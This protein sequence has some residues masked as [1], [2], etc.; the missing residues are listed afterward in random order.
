MSEQKKALKETCVKYSME[1]GFHKMRTSE[2]N[3]IVKRLNYDGAFPK[4]ARSFRDLTLQQAKESA[5]R[6]GVY[7]P[8]SPVTTGGMASKWAKRKLRSQQTA[9]RIE[10]DQLI[11]RER[12]AVEI[13][14]ERYR[15]EKTPAQRTTKDIHE[16]EALRG[17]TSAGGGACIKAP[18]A[19]QTRVAI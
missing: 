15:E 5:R 17:T 4:N 16:T 14:R 2:F 3:D 8:L 9:D 1:N 18:R 12:R 10:C 13:E 19:T 6:D 7:R 11:A